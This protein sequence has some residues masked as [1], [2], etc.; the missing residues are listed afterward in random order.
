MRPSVL[1]LVVCASTLAAC[2]TSVERKRASFRSYRE[3]EIAGRPVKEYLRARQ[4]A[5][6][7]GAD[8]VNAEFRDGQ[9]LL[10]FWFEPRDRSIQSG[11]S[12]GFEMP[13]VVEAVAVPIETRNHFLTAAHA[14]SHRPQHL[15]WSFDG[16]ARAARAEVVW[17]DEG[18]DL[19][20]LRADLGDVPVYPWA[21]AVREGDP[22]LAAAVRSPSAG[23]VRCVGDPANAAG[24]QTF[25]VRHDCPVADG[26]SGCAILDLEGRLVGIH[27]ATGYWLLPPRKTRRAVRPDPAGL[28]AWIRSRPTGEVNSRSP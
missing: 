16:E 3:H 28:Q 2:A 12:F 19:A 18:A 10:S 1:V 25:E 21:P 20:L 6:F 27:S 17:I 7:G 4:V 14:T 8:T 5:L 11:K 24:I 23:R 22:V 26:D 9:T 13:E 15:V